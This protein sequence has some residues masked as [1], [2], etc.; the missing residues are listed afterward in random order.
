MVKV[1]PAELLVKAEAKEKN[2]NLLEAARLYEQVLESLIDKKD[3]KT[4]ATIYENIGNVYQLANFTAET[5]EEHKQWIENSIEAYDKAISLYQEMND[6]VKE[7]ECSAGKLRVKADRGISPEYCKELYLNSFQK[8][9]EVSEIYNKKND[10][11][12]LL[13]ILNQSSITLGFLLQYCDDPVEL[14]QLCQKGDEINE[15]GLNLSYELDYKEYIGTFLF[16]N[17]LIIAIK[18]W[19][20]VSRTYNFIWMHSEQEQML[21]KFLDQCNEGLKYVEQCDDKFN[22]ALIYHSKGSINLQIAARFI[23]D[24]KEQKDLIDKG[25]NFSEKSLDIIREI[26]I[27]PILIH[28]IFWLDYHLAVLGRFQDLQKKIL[29]D[30]NEIKEKGKIYQNLYSF[31]G[32]LTNLLSAF[33]YQNFTQRS[34]L[35]SDLRRIYAKKGIKELEDG[36]KKLPFGPFLPLSYQI[37]TNFYS[38]LVLLT[39]QREKREKIINN[40]FECAYT[41]EKA[42]NKYKAGMS[43][44]AGYLSLYRAHKT[45]S[46]ILTNK[47]EKIKNL[48]IA[49]DATKNHIE[50]SV[51]SYRDFIADWMHLGLLYED[52]AILTKQ[53]EPL[54]QAREL[55]LNIVKDTKEKGY[56]YHTAA[57]YEYIARIEDRLGNHL[58]SAQQY[59]MASKAHIKSLKKIQFKPL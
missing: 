51:E 4:I 28:F 55:F 50:F 3:F 45:L 30:I 40:M 21:N 46:D 17:A 41:A 33:S 44:A 27:K 54:S 25:I 10:K 23:Y 11:N 59:E 31:W 38:Q 8:Y 14:E 1:E 57:A 37:L 2:Y 13:R 22:K 58:A 7:L 48:L 9:F 20:S 5:E 26:N 47:Q 49:I 29:A 35:K 56:Y 34:F 43:R 42:G 6:K 24:E 53:K 36:L 52:L 32:F 16:I 12:N 15:R 18:T 19:I 39:S